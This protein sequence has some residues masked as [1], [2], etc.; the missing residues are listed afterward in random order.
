MLGEDDALLLADALGEEEALKEGLE[1]ALKEG[2][3]ETLVDGDATGISSG[4]ASPLLEFLGLTYS[5]RSF[6]I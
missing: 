5:L 4:A 3:L 1:E 6:G 2:L